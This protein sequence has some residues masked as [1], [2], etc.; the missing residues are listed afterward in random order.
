MGNTLRM[1]K[2]QQIEV[3]AELG[4]SDR[5]IHKQTGID[6]GAI[7]KYR[8]RLEARPGVDAD[9]SSGHGEVASEVPTDLGEEDGDCQDPPEVS[10]GPVVLARTNSSAIRPH[11]EVIGTFFEQRLTAQRIYQDLVE[12]HGYI[13]S[14]DSIKRYVRKLRKHP[15]R[16]AERLEHLPGR[17]A[18]IDFGKATCLVKMDDRYRRPWFFKITLCSS[19]HAYEELVEKQDLETFLRC[20]ER[21]FASFGGVP[22]VVTLDNVKAGVLQPCFFDPV[23]NRTYLAF[24]THWGFAANP[25][26]PRKPEHKGVVERDI[27]YTKHNALDGRRFESLE[28][29]NIFLRHWNERWARTRIHGTTKCQVWKLFCDVEQPLLRPVAEREFEYFHVGVRKVDVN[30]LVEVDARFYGVPTEYV[31][32]EV[33]VHFN[34]QT[35]KIYSGPKLIIAHKRQPIRGRTSIPA[36]CLPSWKHPDLESQERYYCRKASDIGSEM[37]HQVS[38]LLSS[39]DPL[40]IRQVRGLLSLAKTFGDD[41]AEKAASQAH[42][43]GITGYRAVKALCQNIT[44]EPPQAQMSLFTQQHELIRPLSDYDTVISERSI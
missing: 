14:Y 21:A 31:G 10:A 18:Q 16:F 3:L 39:T 9:L 5:A 29:G 40:A 2:I 20:Q 27:G 41:V 33:I 19:K 32:E 34:G 26:Q 17:E 44:T 28:E 4:W 1:E 12:Q 7:A 38:T 22:E 25:C 11:A 13:G 6:R 42:S 35:V 15:R 24:A 37:H 43:A 36:S 8:G 30:G 23:L